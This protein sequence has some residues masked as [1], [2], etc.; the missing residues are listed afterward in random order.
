M[1]Q[2]SSNTFKKFYAGAVVF[3]IGAVILMMIPGNK[4]EG[5]IT[6]GASQSIGIGVIT[7]SNILNGAILNVDVSSTAAIAYSKLNLTGLIV[8]ADV[9]STAAI[10][11][12]KLA[13]TGSIANADVSS[14]AAIAD[15]KLATISTAGKVSGAAL[16]SLSSIPAGA[17]QIPSANVTDPSPNTTSTWAYQEGLTSHALATSSV[18]VSAST[19]GFFFSTKLDATIV[20][21]KITLHVASVT[22]AGTI[23]IAYYSH[24]GQN[25]LFDFTSPS[26]TAGGLVSA[27]GTAVTVQPGIYYV[28]LI[29]NGTTNISVSAWETYVGVDNA[30]NALASEPRLNGSIA[31]LTGGTLPATFD[32]T[33]LANDLDVLPHRLDN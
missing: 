14:T 17:G 30:F 16:T 33:T 15:S 1:Y 11:Y 6:R 4:S 8:N 18:G 9:S 31:G 25:K 29:P 3:I 2:K 27:T 13:L 22:T 23:D 28:A 26:I 24:D 32:P 5:Q 10:A 21:A 19:T 12:S 20:V 7:S